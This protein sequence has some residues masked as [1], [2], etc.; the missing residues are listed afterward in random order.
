MV[1]G[2][3][4]T[5]FFLLLYFKSEEKVAVECVVVGERSGALVVSSLSPHVCVPVFVSFFL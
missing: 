4:G 1:G 2:S 5:P 3:S